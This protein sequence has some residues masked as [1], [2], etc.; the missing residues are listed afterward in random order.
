MVEW[1]CDMD[2]SMD[3]LTG[4]YNRKWIENFIGLN[5]KVKQKVSIAILDLDF[6]NNINKK[7]GYHNGNE[8]LKRIANFFPL[9]KQMVAARYGSDEFILVFI[10]M[11][12]EFI[13]KYINNLFIQFKKSR[14]IALSPYEKVKLT[15]SMGVAHSSNNINGT[16]L[17]LKSAEIALSQAK[18]KG[19]NRIEYAKDKK[20]HI[21]KQ[22]G[23]CTTVIGRSL[24]GYCKNGENAYLASI[25]EPYGVDRDKNGDLLFVDRSNHQIK[26]VHNNRVYT[27]S[28]CGISGYKGDGESSKKAKL[29]K[30]SGV[31]VHKS[32]RMYIADT[33]NHCIRIIEN[34]KISTI[35]G[36]GESGYSG[37]GDIATTA[38]LNRPGGVAVDDKENIYTNDYGNNVIRKIS[39]DGIIT[40]IVGNGEFGYSG[41]LD[42][43]T[44]ASLNRPYGL[45]VEPNGSMLYIADY[46][47]HCIRE[48]NLNTGII[49]TLCGTGEAGY[50]GDGFPCNQAT[51]NGPFWVSLDNNKL[52]IADSNNHCIRKVDLSTKIITTVV[53]NGNQGYVDHIKDLRKI[54]LN[55]PAGM[56]INKDTLYIADYGNNAIRKVKI[57]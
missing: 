49:T 3:Y 6:F 14:F 29:C 18:K 48:V 12:D 2:K 43:A 47:N 34:K 30:P 42:K 40:T 8:V 24:K 56:V 39:K 9:K 31:C 44:K 27:V 37:D 1:D 16:F 41:D 22:E 55:I 5:L 36:S 4:L 52:Y 51:L 38:K 57:S 26:R 10:N 45:C 23:I 28:G 11:K 54:R 21:L 53:G 35:A 19:R 33:G 32:G 25:S 7:I 15:F 50:F 20:L 46:G 17:I 13:K